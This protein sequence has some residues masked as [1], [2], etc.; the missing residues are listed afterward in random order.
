MPRGTETS[1]ED[2]G[3][4]CVLQVD[5]QAKA[6]FRMEEEVTAVCAKVSLPSGMPRGVASGGCVPMAS[7]HRQKVCRTN[8]R[9]PSDLLKLNQWTDRYGRRYGCACVRSDGEI[10]IM[11]CGSRCRGRGGE[12]AERGY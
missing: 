2:V 12:W 1:I 3:A 4:T 8:K 5:Q 11:S 7:K 10:P 9:P 6:V